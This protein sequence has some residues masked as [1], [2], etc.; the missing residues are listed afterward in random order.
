MQGDI[1]KAFSISRARLSSGPVSGTAHVFGYP[2]PTP[3]ISANG[4]ANAIL[5]AVDNKIPA[6]LYAYDARDLSIELYNSGQAPGDRDTFGPGNKFITPTVVNGRV[7]VGTTNGVAVFGLLPTPPAVPD[8]P[9]PANGATDVSTS[10]VLT[11]SAAGATSYDVSFG[12]ATPPPQVATGQ[13]SASYPT[14][15]TTI[16]GATYFWRI[17]AR[18]AVGATPGP[19]WS[20]TTAGGP[21]G[22]FGKSIPPD[23]GR[24]RS[25]S[26]TLSW[27]QSNRGAIGGDT[28]KPRA[29]GD[30]V[31]T[32]ANQS[33]RN[34]G[35]SIKRYE[36]SGQGL[37]L[38]LEQVPF[39]Q[40]VKWLEVLQR[41]YGIIAIEFSASKRDE[42]GMVD[43]RV[44]LKG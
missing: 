21:P 24:G 22:A 10:A 27:M 31:L 42:P 25:T 35:L 6:V 29:A 16:A 17:A 3:S 40:V 1:I 28:Q 19:V 32:L 30:T 33:A 34:L 37:N 43:V 13:T 18:N 9:S 7:Y 39:S 4:N 23:G 11:W 44:T 8:S 26:P 38:W 20:F 5:W 41:D 14:A 12:P 15:G 2:S 36:P